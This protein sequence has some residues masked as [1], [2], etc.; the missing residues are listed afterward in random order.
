MDLD[1]GG[2]DHGIFHVRLVRAGF[3]KPN[4][5][6]GFDPT[7]VSREDTVPLAEEGRQI[8]PWAAS[9]HDPKNSFDKEAIVASTSSRVRRFTRT[10]WF[11]LRPL[12][13]SQHESFH[14]KLESR[15]S[16]T[17]NPEYQQALAVIKQLSVGFDPSAT[18]S[19]PLEYLA[20]RPGSCERADR[21]ASFNWSLNSKMR[22][23]ACFDC[24]ISEVHSRRA[25]TS[26]KCLEHNDQW[27][28]G[29]RMARYFFD[30]RDKGTFSE[31][32]VGVE[33]ADLDV[34]KVEASRALREAVRDIVPGSARAGNGDRSAGRFIQS[35]IA[36][37]V[38]ARAASCVFTMSGMPRGSIPVRA[39]P[40]EGFHRQSTAEEVPMLSDSS[41]RPRHNLPR[42]NQFESELVMD[43]RPTGFKSRGISNTVVTIGSVLAGLL[44]QAVA[45]GDSAAVRGRSGGRC[46]GSVNRRHVDIDPWPPSKPSGPELSASQ[47]GVE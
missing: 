16:P 17:W 6:I 8:A 1:D 29:R 2:V 11:N 13:V 38:G 19:S 5:N 26:S 36:S 4:E 43:D 28:V 44:L 47:P 15:S 22:M 37:A 9:P 21:S 32:D 41:T 45:V 31:D 40:E 20:F 23:R 34:V 33:C 7:S 35:D 46:C 25:P 24:D 27:K 10:M 18:I 14:Q 30:W 42:S 12:G 3:E 39:V